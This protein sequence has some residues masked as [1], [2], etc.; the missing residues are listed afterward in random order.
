[1]TRPEGSEPFFV[2]LL[3][4]VS[5]AIILAAVCANPEYDYSRVFLNT[6]LNPDGST[7][8]VSEAKI[9]EEH[10]FD[11]G[12]PVE[13]A[14]RHKRCGCTARR[15]EWK[16]RN[17]R[18]SPQALPRSLRICADL[19][20]TRLLVSCPVQDI[21]RR[22]PAGGRGASR[23]LSRRLGPAGASRWPARLPALARRGGRG[24]S[25]AAPASSGS[26]AGRQRRA[27]AA[28]GTPSAPVPPLAADLPALMRRGGWASAVARG[29][30]VTCRPCGRRPRGGDPARPGPNMRVQVARLPALA[31]ISHGPVRARSDPSP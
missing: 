14:K 6:H 3:A 30:S 12:N 19:H 23:P 10:T 28:A 17:D 18:L 22:P 31:A 2:V 20:P 15:L 29:A 1:M 24:G 21:S 16:S 25:G 7:P 5:A 8:G 9:R 4:G 27:A 11:W 26:A 13:S